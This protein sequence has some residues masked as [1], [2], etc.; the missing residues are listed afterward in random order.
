MLFKRFQVG[1][2]SWPNFF[3]SYFCILQGEASSGCF[4]T[5]GICQKKVTPF[6][7]DGTGRGSGREDGV[8]TIF[9]IV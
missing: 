3:V 8:S 5:G 6:P 4:L 7:Y 1:F 9:T 2:Y